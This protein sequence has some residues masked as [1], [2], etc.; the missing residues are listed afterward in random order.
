MTFSSSL[1]I[2]RKEGCMC[3]WCGVVKGFVVILWEILISV[4]FIPF[5]WAGGIFQ[6]GSANV[7][8]GGYNLASTILRVERSGEG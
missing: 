1:L 5:S 8:A 3:T 4:V 7:L 2:L 6:K